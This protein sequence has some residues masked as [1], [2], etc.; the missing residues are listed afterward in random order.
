MSG[1]KKGMKLKMNKA[2]LIVAVAGE[3]NLTRR[4]ADKIVNTVFDT[5]TETL[6]KGEKVQLVGFGAFE[7]KKRV[8][9]SGH[10]P[11]TN[12]LIEIP[13]MLLP[14]FRAG[15]ALKEAINKK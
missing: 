15:K 10:N 5:I 7:A 4:E 9:H 12:E 14:Q 3:L 6:R 2:E 13:E 8:G 1:L 11:R